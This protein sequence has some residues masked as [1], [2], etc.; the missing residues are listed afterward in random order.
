MSILFLSHF[1]YM[2]RYTNADTITTARICTTC[3]WS[4]V[5]FFC[6]TQLYGIFTIFFVVFVDIFV[7]MCAQHKLR[8]ALTSCF[9]QNITYFNAVVDV[10]DFICK[11]WRKIVQS[12]V[13]ENICS[14]TIRSVCNAFVLCDSGDWWAFI[15]WFVLPEC[16]GA[17]NGI[18]HFLWVFSKLRID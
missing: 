1:T 4:S 9:I 18:W 8:N 16:V 17:P 2:R 13:R 11:L 6:H 3:L 7:C 10:W 5:F 15:E 12:I 14:F